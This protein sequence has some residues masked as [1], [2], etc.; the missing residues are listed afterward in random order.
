[1]EEVCLICTDKIKG[2]VTLECGHSCC[3]TCFA[4]H[5]RVNNKCPFCRAEFAPPVIKKEKMSIE[6]AQEMASLTLRQS[7]DLCRDL[8]R[9]DARSVEEIT[10]HIAVRAIMN[11]VNWYDTPSVETININNDP[12]FIEILR[13]I[14]EEVTNQNITLPLLE[15]AIPP[16]L[17][18]IERMDNSIQLIPRAHRDIVV[19]IS[20]RATAEILLSMRNIA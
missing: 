19:P 18:E 17:F 13:L 4:K 20:E 15:E 7:R 1:M 12:D 9:D 16:P 11:T 2:K 6:V 14:E 10:L 8:L 5:S 3:V